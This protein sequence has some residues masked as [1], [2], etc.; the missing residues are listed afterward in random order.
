MPDLPRVDNIKIPQGSN[1]SENY[2]K[3]PVE[4]NYD[5]NASHSMMSNSPK[6][7]KYSSI[8]RMLLNEENAD[9]QKLFIKSYKFAINIEDKILLYD[10]DPRLRTHLG[11]KV[12]LS[13]KFGCLGNNKYHE[14]EI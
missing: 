12:K 13:N 11:S 14:R 6:V 7:Q 3:H 2:N 10:K 8:S 4:D 1:K 9:S 5:E